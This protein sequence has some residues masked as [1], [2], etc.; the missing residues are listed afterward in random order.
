[1]GISMLFLIVVGAMGRRAKKLVS[2][3][4]A[5]SGHPG[6]MEE[7]QRLWTIR[8]Y[9]WLAFVA[10]FLI[11]MGILVLGYYRMIGVS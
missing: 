11:G 10:S 7:V 5:K 2:R 6:S 3:G 4:I 9:A 1:M 8:A